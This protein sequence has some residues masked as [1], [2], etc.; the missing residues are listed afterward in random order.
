MKIL[1]EED[2][3]GMSSDEKVLYVKL[4]RNGS[5]SLEDLYSVPKAYFPSGVGKVT[6]IDAYNVTRHVRDCWNN[7]DRNM[8]SYWLIDLE[9]V[10]VIKP[11]DPCDGDYMEK[12][13]S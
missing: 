2:I 1:T 3:W 11:D 9:E 7:E 4:A 10:P 6:N 12:I 13:S 8:D 5:V